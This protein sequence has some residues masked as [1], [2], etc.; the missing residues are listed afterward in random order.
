[1][2]RIEVDVVGDVSSLGRE[3]RRGSGMVRGFASSTG[4]V[5]KGVVGANLVTAGASAAVE[6]VRQL[7]GVLGES[8]DEAREA[9]K[10]GAVTTQVIRATGGAAKV[11]ADE[12]GD[13]ATALS[14]KAGIDDEV[15]QSGANLLLT[16]KN[17]R[18]EAGK[19]GAIFDRATAAA[20]DLSATG[21]GSVAAGSKML[22]KAL[23]D[24][25]KGISAL[26][27][28]GVT[29]S[30][31]QQKRIKSMVAEND[32][33]G[34][35]KLI[36]AEVESQ[37]GGVAA[38]QATAG[39]KA[40]VMAGNLKE[41]LGTALL[42]TLDRLAG[43][44]VST[45]GPAISRGIDQ[46]GP[47]L[48]RVSGFVGPIVDDVL[49]I[50]TSLASGLGGGGAVAGFIAEL[51]P[52][53]PTV[54]G[55]VQQV[56]PA[57][58]GVV[59]QI[60]GLGAAVLPVI[61]GIASTA[62]PL[63]AGIVGQVGGLI[64]QL[65]PQVAGLVGQI[66]GVVQAVLPGIAGVV[67]GVI[68]VV[69]T[70]APIVLQV[71]GAVVGAIQ[72][73]LPAI[74]GALGSLRSIFTSTVSIIAS[75]WGR[76][77]PIL[78][79]I[80]AGTVGNIIRIVST[81]LQLVAQ[82]FRT[83]AAV[84]RGDWSGAWRG[85]QQIAGTVISVVLGLVN[86]LRSGLSAA[87]AGIRSAAAA[88]W[89]AVRSTASAAWSALVGI[90]RSRTSSV[91]ATVRGIPGQIRAALGN[92]GGLLISSG[93]ALIDG[94]AS[95]IR[96]RIGAAISA[97]SDA[98]SAIRDFFPGSPAKRGPFS[99]RG[100]T[101]YSGRAVGD[102][103]ATGLVQRRRQVAAA[104]EALAAAARPVVVAPTSAT[105]RASAAAVGAPSAAGDLAAAAAAFDFAALEAALERAVQRGIEARLAPVDDRAAFVL[106][107]RGDRFARRGGRR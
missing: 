43:F 33:L 35:Q 89:N 32:L 86:R 14:N 61:L 46:V 8:V 38:A 2:P 102:A 69:R 42:P 25:V 85:I 97:A 58:L 80:L 16:F 104:G 27:R 41:Q 99:G 94:F 18:N 56:G 84:L 29:F 47:A 83:V 91:L 10:V 44:F 90:V 100:W 7:F 4:S 54:L 75:V 95:G 72:A 15:I 98:V 5:L 11:S 40:R 51:A 103:M 79:P 67:M 49:S 65:A 26:S 50:G 78:L 106:V 6:G 28:A 21:F 55:I 31:G 13:L 19:G 59:Q 9:Q 70:L 24:P 3:L 30:A 53:A 23:N 62:A 60:A 22:G 101:L 36:L 39:E 66:G 17:V 57:L 76:L 37:V 74:M 105:L 52:L 12:V 82:I 1:M 20:V 81:G 107:E 64:A 45:L 68:G 63:I 73:N 87:F 92:L 48:D 34:A 77:G 93:A 96:S 88:A 71:F